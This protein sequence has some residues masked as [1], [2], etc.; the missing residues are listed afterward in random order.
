M[1]VL[2][3]RFS[4]FIISLYGIL[5]LGCTSS[6]KSVST[7]LYEKSGT[8]LWAENCGR[9]H[10][11]PPPSA[12]EPAEWDVV[13]LHMRMRTY[14]TGKEIEKIEQFLMKE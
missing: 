12:F 14:L 11:A 5:S 6:S 7:E 4:F 9:C 8:E 2:I 10:N 13:S 3:L 1:K